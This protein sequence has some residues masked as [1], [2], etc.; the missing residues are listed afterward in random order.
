[1]AK[2][3]RTLSAKVNPDGQS[4]ILLR[5]GISRQ[6]QLRLRSGVYVNPRIFRDGEIADPKGR[7]PGAFREASLARAELAKVE[8][9]LLAAA[10]ENP[11][12][13]KE[14]LEK[15]TRGPAGKRRRDPSD[16]FGLWVEM[17]SE[18]G[19]SESR[20][21]TLRCVGRMLW[22]WQRHGRR[23]LDPGSVTDGD[24]REFERYVRTEGTVYPSYPARLTD[25]P[26]GLEIAARESARRA[27]GDNSVSVMMQAVRKFLIWCERRGVATLRPFDLYSPPR[28]RYGKPWHLTA[29]ERDA[30]AALDAEGALAEARDRFVLQCLVGCRQGDLNRLREDDVSGG[31]LEYVPGKTAGKSPAPVRVPLCDAA[32]GIIRRHKGRHGGSLVAPMR[33]EKYNA[34][35]RKLCALARIERLVTVLDPLTGRERKER[36]CDVAT[37]HLARRTFI[38]VLYKK[39][40]DPNL[41]GSMSGHVEGSKAFARYR[42][43]DDE[44]KREVIGLL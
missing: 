35:I 19:L 3:T 26:E 33:P 31:V 20:R 22:R 30:I 29:E 10:V 32:L 14:E 36:I 5:I 44:L 1:M 34:L 40:K 16:F 8:G 27:R 4:E 2:I 42:T 23:V 11:D 18:R 43:I 12:I 25:Y 6:R 28:E 39:V 24:L 15:L 21:N 13:P 7:D 41:I 37:S 38:G 9:D 17:A